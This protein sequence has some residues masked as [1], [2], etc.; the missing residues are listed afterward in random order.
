MTIYKVVFHTEWLIKAD[1]DEEDVEIIAKA[2]ES[3]NDGNMDIGTYLSEIA[4]V[5]PTGNFQI[6][7]VNDAV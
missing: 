4:E 1:P 3:M 6:E 5:T 7:E 2:L